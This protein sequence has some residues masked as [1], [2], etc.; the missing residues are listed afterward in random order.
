MF[1]RR[2]L[3]KLR[4]M[5]L[6][7]VA[8]RLREK[9]C[10]NWERVLYSS[11][12][13][14]TVRMHSG[15]GAC[16]LSAAQALVPGTKFEQLQLLRESR[17]AEF[18]VLRQSVIQRADRIIS[19]KWPMLGHELQLS[20][21][22]DWHRDPRTGYEWPRIFHSDVDVHCHIPDGVDVKYIWELGRQQYCS[23]LALAWCLT[24]K[25]I[26]ADRCRSLI[27]DWI[28]AN[29]PGYG[30]HWT[31][32]LEVAM[33][34]ISWIWSLAGLRDWGEWT[35]EQLEV[36][37]ASLVDHA[38]YL[39]RH[40][41]YYSSPYNHLMGE[42]TG[43]LLLGHALQHLPRAIRWREKARRILLQ[44]GPRQFYR[45]GFTVEQ[46]MGYHFY[47][48]GFL[49]MALL[50]ERRNGSPLSELETIVQRAFK[51]AIH[52]RRPDGRWP[53]I[54][55]VDSAR[56]IP[57]YPKDF[58]NFESICSLGAV[59]FRDSYLKTS[60]GWAGEEAYWLT[61]VEGLG[62]WDALPR[63]SAKSST[64]LR[65]SGY[66][67]ARD[68]KDWI[69][70]D[71]GPV[72]AGLHDDEVPSTA[73]G[74]VDVLQVLYCKDGRPLLVDSGMPFYC[75]PEAW[76]RFF[77]GAE[78]HNTIAVEGA[79]PA[80]YAGRLDWSHARSQPNMAAQFAGAIHAAV[81][82]A[83]WGDGV[84][85]KRHILWIPPMGLWIA[86]YVNCDRPR[87]VAWYWQPGESLVVSNDDGPED[88]CDT[89]GAAALRAWNIAGR[90]QWHVETSANDSPVGWRAPGYGELFSSR[91]VSYRET[92]NN[93]TL[94]VTHVGS[95]LPFEVTYRGF[96]I[97]CGEEPLGDGFSCETDASPA[98]SEFLWT[99]W[100]EPEPISVRISIDGMETAGRLGQFH[101][102]A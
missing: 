9:L 49:S 37:V 87:E 12:F 92:V 101:S 46:A 102:I 2:Q 44:Y 56:S 83:E 51:V 22:I 45:D 64:V 58:W 38:E 74:H 1:S 36:I 69:L 82:C 19:G 60:G 50:V 71:A 63:N 28:A 47:T 27:L 11:R 8:G 99:I 90:V 75:G 24:R 61:G 77:R 20:D 32:A 13:R 10:T 54:G 53:A 59:L 76:I 33:R 85:V 14:S 35:E 88:A 93:S 62:V 6:A 84:I 98:D 23:E 5:P 68:Q 65:E 55:D 15:S 100:D 79:P 42:G 31:S 72:A 30:V 17:T 73:H 89:S 3:V 4:K 34:A 52:M 96:R 78:A 67:I 48:L 25:D 18:V 43:L 21:S 7:E 39:H 70:F 41:S 95:L 57:V 91:R 40:P 97:Q 29:P 94:V 81:G 26:Y 86:D 80:R 66:F 16:V